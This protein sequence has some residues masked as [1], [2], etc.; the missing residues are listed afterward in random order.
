M[1]LID[2]LHASDRY[3]AAMQA[4]STVQ[5]SR[6][7]TSLT[8]P[9]HCGSSEQGTF[10]AVLSSD[11]Y[12]WRVERLGAVIR[13]GV[14]WK[15]AGEGSWR[16]WCCT[17]SGWQNADSGRERWRCVGRR[18]GDPRAGTRLT[19]CGRTSRSLV[20][21]GWARCAGRG[22]SSSATPRTTEG[23][24]SGSPGLAAGGRGLH[25]RAAGL[26]L[27]PWRKPRRPDAQRAPGSR[28]R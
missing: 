14:G 19:G 27:S 5:S 4:S 23:G 6:L 24:R 17:D 9:S 3:P 1:E 28:P 8:L 2:E 22:T 25:D 16:V 20:T 21:A 18:A 15:Q 7:A 13:Y 26:G 12:G 11:D 10:G